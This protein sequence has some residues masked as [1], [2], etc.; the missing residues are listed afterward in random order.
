MSYLAAFLAGGL[1]V[2]AVVLLIVMFTVDSL[3]EAA[4]HINAALA[5]LDQRRVSRDLSDWE[6]SLARAGVEDR[7]R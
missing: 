6:A 3:H 7:R 5:E 4:R 1:A 2:G